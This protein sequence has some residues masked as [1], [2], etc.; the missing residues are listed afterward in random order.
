MKDM[1]VLNQLAIPVAKQLKA[2]FGSIQES[3]E[4]ILQKASRVN[5]GLF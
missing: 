2:R 1:G 5:L 3:N 4:N